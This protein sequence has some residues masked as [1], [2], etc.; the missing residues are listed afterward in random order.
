MP[1]YTLPDFNLLAS[2]WLTTHNPGSDPA[3]YEDV[4][5]QKYVNSRPQQDITPRWDASAGTWIEWCPIIALRFPRGVTAFAGSW[6]GWQVGLVRVP[7][8]V[9]QVYRV[10]MGEVIHEGFPNEYVQL[11]CDQV[12]DG[13]LAPVPQWP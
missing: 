7:Q 13:I 5:C 10:R 8:D 11:I 4:P 1:T 9:S 6:L 3:D 12:D 2:L